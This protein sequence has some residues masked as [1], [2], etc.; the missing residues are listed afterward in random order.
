MKRFSD[1]PLPPSDLQKLVGSHT[2]ESFIEVGIAFADYFKQRELVKKHYKILEPG[3]GCGRISKHLISELDPSL[4][5]E[6]HGFD[7]HKECIEWAIENITKTYPHFHFKHTDVYNHLYNPKGNIKNLSRMVFPYEENYFD[8]IYT[9]SFFTHLSREHLEYYLRA[10]HKLC[11][12]G[13]TVSSSFFTYNDIQE[14]EHISEKEMG[15]KNQYYKFDD[16][17]YI[18]SQKNPSLVV[19]YNIEYLKNFIEE[20]GFSLIQS[21]TGWQSAWIFKKE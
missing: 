8:F 10:I 17:S 7:V 5:G 21:S 9:A 20:A 14:F 12:N 4:G 16:V 3:C 13:G 6:Y 19:T 18:F 1:V 11:K 15:M 2:P